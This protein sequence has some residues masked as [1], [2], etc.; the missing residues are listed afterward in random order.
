MDLPDPGIK[1]GSPALQVDSLPDELYGSPF[2]GGSV[3]KNPPTNAE[4]ARDMGS[5]PGSGQSPG[6]GIGDLL[7]YSCL[8]NAMDRGAWQAAVHGVA[9]SWTQLNTC[10]STY[11]I[12][13][14]QFSSVQLLSRVRL[15]AT[16]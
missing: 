11:H 13:S 2:P 15:F 14:V 16:P 3:V 8:G 4:D 12:S 5:I 10:V 1:L 9:K 7:Q 6:E